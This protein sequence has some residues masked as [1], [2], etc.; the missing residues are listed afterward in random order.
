VQID[1]TI[2][3]ERRYVQYRFFRY[4][5][6]IGME[7]SPMDLRD[8]ESFLAIVEHQSITRAAEALGIAQPPLSRRIAALEREFGVT[9]L[10]RQHRQI[11]LTDA[12]HVFVQ[13][14]RTLVRHAS[15]IPYAV[16]SAA[17]DATGYVR[18]GFV[19]SLAHTIVP[20]VLRRFG[21]RNPN[22]HV[23][24][25]ESL[26]AHQIDALRAGLIDLALVRGPVDA[27]DLT[28]IPLRT[29]RLGVMLPRRHRLLKRSALRLSEV[30]DEPIITFNR[31][32]ATGLHDVIRGAFA[33]AGFAPKFAREVDSIDAMLAYV[34]GNMGIALLY[35]VAAAK[36]SGV[37]YRPL[38][39]V[40]TQVAL[41][42]VHRPNDANH[43]VAALV[44]VAQEIAKLG[45]RGQKSR[46]AT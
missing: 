12:G 40:G 42:A 16:R 2:L 36:P 37:E 7:R 3:N 9:L 27:V 28:T 5:Y 46:H 33:Q 13:E 14:A 8:A 19:G 26:G 30:V 18:L 24:L 6:L 38:S 1:T 17:K 44:E 25:R 43:A 22:V 29:D 39:P 4:E 32:G 20:Q 35:E 34:A 15:G 41:S 23:M 21:T 45:E 10:T 31:Y 11:Q